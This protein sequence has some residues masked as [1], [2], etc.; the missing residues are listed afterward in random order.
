MHPLEMANVAYGSRPPN[1]S[2]PGCEQILL[3]R[4]DPQAVLHERRDQHMP[5]GVSKRASVRA[6]GLTGITRAASDFSEL[7]RTLSIS[8]GLPHPCF[9]PVLLA[10]PSLFWEIFGETFSIETKTSFDRN[11]W[12]TGQF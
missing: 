12:G 7:P 2:L 11:F 5:D 10:P 3:L 4:L 8:W 1:L 6:A 9:S